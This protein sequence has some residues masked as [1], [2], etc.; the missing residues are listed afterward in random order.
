MLK[1]VLIKV[2]DLKLV[3]T[4]AQFFRAQYTHDRDMIQGISR[5]DG[6]ASLDQ[7]SYGYLKKKDPDFILLNSKDFGQFFE[8]DLDSSYLKAADYIKSL[9]NGQLGYKTVFYRHTESVPKWTYPPQI[10]FL[11]DDIDMIIMQKN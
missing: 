10:G 7:Y 9:L 1:N 5:F 4:Q 3:D 2:E 11:D 6:D 8:N